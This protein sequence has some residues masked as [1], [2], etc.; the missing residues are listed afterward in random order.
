MVLERGGVNDLLLSGVVHVV[1]TMFHYPARVEPTLFLVHLSQAFSMSVNVRIYPL[2]Y[3]FG[4]L[5]NCFSGSFLIVICLF[6]LGA[7]S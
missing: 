6:C 2:G 1:F 4:A 7:L 3:I 5:F